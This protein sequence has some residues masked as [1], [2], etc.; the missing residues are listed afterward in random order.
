MLGLFDLLSPASA[1]KKFQQQFTPSKKASFNPTTFDATADVLSDVSI[2]V[3][4]VAST[5]KPIQPSS[6]PLFSTP[7]K[8]R[9]T[10]PVNTYLQPDLSTTPLPH[11]HI[12][13]PQSSGKRKFLDAFLT[14]STRRANALSAYVLGDGPEEK[15]P[16]SRGKRSA[17]SLQDPTI[18]SIRSRDLL[19]PSQAAAL[20]LSELDATP[21]FL[22]RFT[23]PVAQPLKHGNESLLG[24]DIPAPRL[25][26]RKPLGRSLSEMIRSVREEEDERLDEEAEIMRE[27]EMEEEDEAPPKRPK[28]LVRDSQA[29]I[30]RPSGE[31]GTGKEIAGGSAGNEGEKE[32]EMRLGA[33][34]EWDSEDEE[35]PVEDGHDKN[36]GDGRKWKKKGQKRTTRRAKMKPRTEKWVPE[37]EWTVDQVEDKN[38]EAEAEKER[39]DEV[40][41]ETQAN[42]TIDGD[43]IIID[44]GSDAYEN[45]AQSEDEEDDDKQS[46]GTRKRGR[47]KSQATKIPEK[48]SSKGKTKVKEKAEEKEKKNPRKVSAT[49]HANF[50]ALKIRNKNSRGRG[51]GRGGRFGRRR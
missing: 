34:G 17:P 46:R 33:D 20:P 5:S 15:T 26:R 22:R 9:T 49:A 12:R 43:H 44:D 16:S 48:N 40:V 19:A 29:R 10:A 30:V 7:S 50:R 27:L 1:K 11:R 18:T 35:E 47:P 23:A 13:T 31:A 3:A 38:V 39:G 42:D 24:V 51:G 32:K 25:P 36:G 45:T 2:S 14:P 37:K 41:G 8:T 4:P 21:A 6:L 28:I